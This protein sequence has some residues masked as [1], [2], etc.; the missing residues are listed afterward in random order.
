MR[1]QEA[2]DFSIREDSPERSP[3][4]PPEGY[5]GFAGFHKYWGKKPTEAWNLLIERL[6]KPEDI[7]LD[8]FLGSGLVAKECTDLNRRFI[9]TPDNF[10]RR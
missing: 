9:N 2:F 5:K 3:A 6:T 4:R 8:P 7:V 10:K 1:S